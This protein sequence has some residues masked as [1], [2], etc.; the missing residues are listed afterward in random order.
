MSGGRRLGVCIV[1]CGTIARTHAGAIGLNDELFLAGVCDRNASA[2]GEF[3]KAHGTRTFSSVEEACASDGVDILAVCTPSGTH[4]N[5]ARE[6]LTRGKH[7][8]VEKPV[9]LKRE[10]CE[11][12]K[13]LADEKGLVCTMIAQQRFSDTA[14][15]VKEAVESGRFGKIVLVTLDMKYYRAQDYYDGSNWK[16][17]IEQDGGVLMNQGIHGVDLLCGFLGKPRVVSASV[18]TMDKRIEADDIAVASVEFPCGAPGVVTCTVYAYPGYPRRIE[19]NGTKGSVLIEENDV[20]RWD[21]DGD[22]PVST[23]PKT[24]GYRD[25]FVSD[26]TMHARQYKDVASHI[27]NGTPLEYSLDDAEASISCIEEIYRYRQAK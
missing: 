13:A 16:G 18:K 9:A 6:I 21:I 24:S 8:I 11:E 26:F 20:A 15:H 5:I 19:I 3:A 4:F 23:I 22:A 1:G 17:S 2:A 10:E 25:H 27:L 7:A 14:K 12:L